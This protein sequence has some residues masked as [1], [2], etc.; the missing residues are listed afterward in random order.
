MKQQQLNLTTNAPAM[1][2]DEYEFEPIR[3]QPTLKWNGKR[4]FT[5]TR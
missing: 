4:S 3:G 1:A 5:A 2:V